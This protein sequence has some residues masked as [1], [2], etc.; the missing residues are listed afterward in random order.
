MSPVHVAVGTKDEF[1]LCLPWE[2]ALGGQHPF[3]LLQES[4]C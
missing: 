4:S 2:K 1:E 3:L